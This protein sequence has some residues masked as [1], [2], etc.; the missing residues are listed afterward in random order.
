MGSRG[1]APGGGPPEVESFL[2][3]FLQK[4]WPKVKDLSENLPPCLSR[5]A[6]TSP[7]FWP[8]VGGRPPRPPIAGSATGKWH[9]GGAPS[10]VQGQSPWSPEVESFLY[11]F[12]KKVAKS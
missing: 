4:K 1:R 3:I 2:Y 9:Y 5:A 6:M 7:N 12:C 8:M 11:I 10:G